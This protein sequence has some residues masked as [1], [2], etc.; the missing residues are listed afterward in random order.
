MSNLLQKVI[1]A[2]LCIALL[3][4]AL[5]FNAFAVSNTRSAFSGAYGDVDGNGSVNSNDAL[6]VLVYSVGNAKFTE[7]QMLAADVN[8]DGNV[9]SADA[10]NILQYS[11]GTLT[12]FKAE[13]QNKQ[14]DSKQGLAEFSD[15]I[16]AVGSRLPSY[17][18][19]EKVV[20]NADD[21]TL[22][23]AALE[24][25]P[26]SKISELEQSI[27]KEYAKNQVY[28]TIVKQSTTAS[29]EEMIKSF[30]KSNVTLN[31]LK[32]VSVTINE[33][34][35]KIINISFKDEKNPSESSPIV[36]IF[37]ME[38]YSKVKDELSQGDFAGLNVKVESLNIWY[39]NA[40]LSC[41]FNSDTSE[42]I[43][44]SWSLET[45]SE[46]KVS[47]SYMF[48]GF[49]VEVKLSGE[50]GETFSNFGY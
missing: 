26:Q 19:R 4:A 20:D 39:K 21:I 29:A 47:T 28:T 50:R 27:Q 34:G 16:S 45:V 31:D 10:L 35:N 33:N 32:S 22:S 36:K 5:C 8:A 42:L 11:V 44:L 13:E 43:A 37:G 6:C 3:C 38:S 30:T 1:S 2:L 12:H 24:I 46:S 23:G 40:T 41:E 25:L 49:S 15:A 18:L 14:Y 48:T 9:N 7:Q 17:L